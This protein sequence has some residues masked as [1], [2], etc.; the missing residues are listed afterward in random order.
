MKLQK[1]GLVAMAIVVGLSALY[2]PRAEAFSLMESIRSFFGVKR[3]EQ[4]APATNV[5]T[6]KAP[7]TAAT[8]KVAIPAFNQG[9]TST[10]FAFQLDGYK[11]FKTMSTG[12][13]KLLK[14]TFQ[15]DSGQAFTTDVPAD[16]VF[17]RAGDN[18]VGYS[19]MDKRFYTISKTSDGLIDKK[20][21]DAATGQI[22]ESAAIPA[23]QGIEGG[24]FHMD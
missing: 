3:V 10:E 13:I 21:T 22:I 24:T 18:M 16:M 17:T 15:N 4:S 7:T 9:I 5:R 23:F 14:L 19:E 6:T 12:D 20:V 8:R 2:A 1:T 11:V